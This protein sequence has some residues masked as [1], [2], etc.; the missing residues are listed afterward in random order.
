MNVW[1]ET[2]H[3]GIKAWNI[4]IINIQNLYTDINASVNAPNLVETADNIFALAE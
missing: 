2:R 1:N 3:D 4:T